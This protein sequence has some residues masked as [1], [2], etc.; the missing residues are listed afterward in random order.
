MYFSILL[1]Y[2]F[3]YVIITV[4]GYFIERFINICNNQ[5]IK[6]WGLKRT[7]SC[8]LQTKISIKDF[9]R[10]KEIAR[11]TKCKINIKD[12]KGMPFF[13]HKYRKRKV[14]AVMML[15]V[16]FSIFYS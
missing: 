2:I 16:V 8:L 5:K 14:L 3:G 13:I 10:I 9:K 11:K 15:V 12:K 7:N 6:L 1:N 4:E